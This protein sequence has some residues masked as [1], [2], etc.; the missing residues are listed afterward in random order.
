MNGKAC[1][2]TGHRHAPTSE[3]ADRVGAQPTISVAGDC[4]LVWLD[5]GTSE[6]D[7]PGPSTNVAE[8]VRG[9]P[10]RT[11]NCCGLRDDSSRRPW[12]GSNMVTSVG[13]GSDWEDKH[14]GAKAGSVMPTIEASGSG[15]VCKKKALF[16]DDPMRPP[17]R[18]SRS[19]TKN[20]NKKK[21][22]KK[23]KKKRRRRGCLVWSAK[24]LSEAAAFRS[25]E[26]PER[27]SA[28]SRYHSGHSFS[29]VTQRDNVHRNSETEKQ[30]IDRARYAGDAKRPAS[31]GGFVSRFAKSCYMGQSSGACTIRAGMMDQST[32]HAQA[33][34]VK[35]E[36]R[37]ASRRAAR[38]GETARMQWWEND[39]AMNSRVALHCHPPA[40]PASCMLQQL[41][42]MGVDTYLPELEDGAALDRRGRRYHGPTCSGGF[43]SSRT[44]TWKM[45][46]ALNERILGQT[47]TRTLPLTV[48]VACR[49]E[50]KGAPYVTREKDGNSPNRKI[51]GQVGNEMSHATRTN[52]IEAVYARKKSGWINIVEG[53][54]RERERLAAGH[55]CEL[56]GRREVVK[57]RLWLITEGHANDGAAGDAVRWSF[58]EHVSDVGEGRTERG[59]AGMARTLR[60]AILYSGSFPETGSAEGSDPQ[61]LGMSRTEHATVGTV[62]ALRGR[63][64]WILR[65]AVFTWNSKPQASLA[66]IGI[67]VPN[68]ILLSDRVQPTRSHPNFAGPAR[69]TCDKSSG[70]PGERR[71]KGGGYGGVIHANIKFT[72]ATLPDGGIAYFSAAGFRLRNCSFEVYLLGNIV[73]SARYH[74]IIY[75]RSTAITVGPAVPIADL[76]ERNGR[77]NTLNR[78]LLPLSSCLESEGASLTLTS[79][80]QGCEEIQRESLIKGGP[81]EL[82]NNGGFNRHDS[83][84]SGG[85]KPSWRWLIL[86]TERSFNWLAHQLSAHVFEPAKSRYY[87]HSQ[88]G[89]KWGPNNILPKRSSRTSV[90]HPFYLQWLGNIMNI[91]WVRLSNHELL[92]PTFIDVHNELKVI[93][94]LL[95]ELGFGTENPEMP[96]AVTGLIWSHTTALAALHISLSTPKTSQKS[97]EHVNVALGTF[98]LKEFEPKIL[99]R[100]LGSTGCFN[101]NIVYQLDWSIFVAFLQYR[102]PVIKIILDHLRREIAGGR[103]PSPKEAKDPY[104]T[105]SSS[106]AAPS[107][108]GN[109]A[110]AGIIRAGIVAWT[111]K[112]VLVPARV[113][114]KDHW[115]NSSSTVSGCHHAVVRGLCRPVH[116]AHSVAPVLNLGHLSGLA[117]RLE[118]AYVV[119]NSPSVLA[120]TSTSYPFSAPP[121]LLVRPFTSSLHL[122]RY[123][124]YLVS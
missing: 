4:R 68:P 73:G 66:R 89:C 93:L 58:Q 41:Q 49:K 77:N 103:K 91:G 97:P 13:V 112:R 30:P 55:G 105:C 1:C 121:S 100:C 118:P 26:A 117:S 52:F 31:A 123:P 39:S 122:P 70:A 104:V 34:G 95:G 56:R 76:A 102:D 87:F 47:S 50:G 111:R 54:C 67:G 22:K 110:R 96:Q 85:S 57:L 84:G 12:C 108:A 61:Q 48:S 11:S 86:D 113:R 98:F 71:R 109:F 10:E 107:G 40:S 9:P 6:R 14:R 33:R 32:L 21:K 92:V 63:R 19:N 24:Q 38:E 79:P 7:I 37:N 120:V 59:I 60:G 15:A 35:A 5:E 69:H 81:G 3:R 8:N 46:M 27:F 20:K 64:Y 44:L 116:R 43:A 29:E 78:G 106:V 53:V 88:W 65:W 17:S 119:I 83:L 90:S 16:F 94:R 45:R 62:E 80:P 99:K 2:V 115:R 82:T 114:V 28:S 72:Y 36:H 42:V 25:K 124:T 75:H 18:R 23:K 101:F 51:N 74:E